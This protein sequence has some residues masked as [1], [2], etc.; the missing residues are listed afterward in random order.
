MDLLIVLPHGNDFVFEKKTSSSSLQSIFSIRRWL[1]T[2]GILHMPAT[3]DL[4]YNSISIFRACG[5]VRTP[6]VLKYKAFKGSKF[7]QI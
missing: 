1:R 5:Q 7:P 4:G 6:S 2:C 3:Q